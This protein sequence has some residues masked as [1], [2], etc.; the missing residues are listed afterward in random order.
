MK[1]YKILNIIE[2]KEKEL[3]DKLEEYNKSNNK[4]EKV[5]AKYNN[6]FAFIISLST[7]IIIYY[8][9][10]DVIHG[11]MAYADILL[12][13]EYSSALEYEFKWFI[14][15]LTNFNKSFFAYSKVL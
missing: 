15:H 4:L 13:I 9:G 6:I 11:A 14:K 7:A 3:K 12:M 1:E 5:V 8:G 10:L 2:K